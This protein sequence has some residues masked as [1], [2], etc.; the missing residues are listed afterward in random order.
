LL[1][2]RIEK[3]FA[4]KFAH[5]NGLASPSFN[6]PIQSSKSYNNLQIPQWSTS[7]HSP[8]TKSQT[9]P[10]GLSSVETTNPPSQPVFKTSSPASDVNV[11]RHP[12]STSLVSTETTVFGQALTSEIS[13]TT[14]HS[15]RPSQTSNIPASKL[16]LA[17]SSTSRALSPS[18]SYASLPSAPPE[19]ADSMTRSPN[20]TS[21][22]TSLEPHPPIIATTPAQS[23]SPKSPNKEQ[24]ADSASKRLSAARKRSSLENLPGLDAGIKRPITPGRAKRRAAGRSPVTTPTVASEGESDTVVLVQ[25]PRTEKEHSKKHVH[26]RRT[27][28]QTEHEH[29]VSPSTD[30]M[31]EQDLDETF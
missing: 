15:R 22:E 25:V 17:S 8:L 29:Q 30:Q 24:L 6:T 9:Q 28:S 14:G 5:T 16:P 13:S 11:S 10:N 4:R 12:R 27:R 18:A 23:T 21:N 1:S 7:R 20:I 26:H 3:A 2:D 19:E 31:Q